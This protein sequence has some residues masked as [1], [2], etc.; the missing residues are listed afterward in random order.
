MH[1][2]ASHPEVWVKS[3]LVGTAISASRA[4]SH[5]SAEVKPPTIVSTINAD[6]VAGGDKEKACDDDF[7][8][9]GS[10]PPQIFDS[11]FQRWIDFGAIVR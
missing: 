3:T 2:V 9:H 10:N 7:T 11:A 5:A 6:V 4:V 8:I 1:G